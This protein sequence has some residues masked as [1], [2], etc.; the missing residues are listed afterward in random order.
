MKKAVINVMLIVSLASSIACSNR[1]EKLPYY[2]TPDFT[3]QWMNKREANEKIPHV[4]DGFNFTDQNAV[5]F[6]NKNI[7]GKIHVANFFLPLVPEY[8]LK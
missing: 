6:S 2:N 1:E 3:P 5:S 7:E 8:A 4:I